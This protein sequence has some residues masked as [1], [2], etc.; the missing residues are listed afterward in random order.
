MLVETNMTVY[1]QLVFDD[2]I[3][4]LMLLSDELMLFSQTPYT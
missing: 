3:T 1:W 4:E 2:C